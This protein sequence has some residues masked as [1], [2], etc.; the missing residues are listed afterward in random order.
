MDPLTRPLDLLEHTIAQR[1]QSR[2]EKSYTRELLAGGLDAIGVKILEE[3]A[4]LV[5]AAA[6]TGEEARTH[7][8]H[9][10]ADLV[11]H[12]LVL[13]QYK[14]VSLVDV[15]KELA[16]RFGVS[17]IEEKKNRGPNPQS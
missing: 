2:G 6:E 11:Y 9:E 12:L 8:L 17:G 13:L 5:E 15:E 14:E 7:F 1:A 16:G 3:A 4:E 10:V